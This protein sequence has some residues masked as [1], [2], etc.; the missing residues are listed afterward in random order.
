MFGGRST[1]K[2]ELRHERRARETGIK[3]KLLGRWMFVGVYVCKRVYMLYFKKSWPI[4]YIKI[5]Y[6][7]C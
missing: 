2:K 1:R 4:L 7:L 5:L 6:E 3:D